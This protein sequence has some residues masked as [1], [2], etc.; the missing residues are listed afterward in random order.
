MPFL[1]S[2]GFAIRPQRIPAFS[3]R[4]NNKQ[5]INTNPKCGALFMWRIT[6]PYI[7]SCWIANPA[8]QVTRRGGCVEEI[9][10]FA[11]NDDAKR[12]EVKGGRRIFAPQKFF[13]PL[14]L[15]HTIT[16]IPQPSNARQGISS[17]NV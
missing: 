1:C 6:N 13:F 4:Q 3:M 5:Q 15:L 10:R 17:R 11:R 9:P 2:G 7:H 16:V 8:E 12:G 14:P